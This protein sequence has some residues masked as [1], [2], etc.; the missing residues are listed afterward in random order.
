[1]IQQSWSGPEYFRIH[2]K[3]SFTLPQAQQ[4]N[5]RQI[6]IARWEKKELILT[7]ILML[8]A[9]MTDTGKLMQ[10]LCEPSSARSGHSMTDAN[11]GKQR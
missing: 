1:M 8:R 11:N 4:S 5:I 7:A 9:D 6:N 2:A 10:V 3:H